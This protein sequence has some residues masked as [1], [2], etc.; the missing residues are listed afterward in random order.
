MFK[1]QEMNMK[2]SF[3]WKNSSI[4]LYIIEKNHL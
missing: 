4:I 3:H 2:K 1:K